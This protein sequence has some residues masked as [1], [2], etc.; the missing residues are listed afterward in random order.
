MALTR[1]GGVV[2]RKYTKLLG[3]MICALRDTVSKR[4]GELGAPY[5]LYGYFGCLNAPLYFL[6]WRYVNPEI[7]ENGDLRVLCVLL[8]IPLILHRR[9]PETWRKWLPLY[10]YATL[11]ITLPAFFTCLLVMNQGS[12]MWMANHIV[13]VFFV[14]LLVDSISALWLLSLGTVLGIAFAG[15]LSPH[16]MIALQTHLYPGFPITYAISVV[17]GLLFCRNREQLEKITCKNLQLAAECAEKELFIANLSHDLRTPLTGLVG[18]ADYALQA[19]TP[20]HPHYDTLHIMHQSA[21]QL[22]HFCEN[23]LDSAKLIQADP[24]PPPAERFTMQ[25]LAKRIAHLL[26]PALTRKKLTLNIQASDTDQTRPLIGH[27][28]W[29]TLILIHLINNAI[30][31]TET[32]TITLGWEIQGKHKQ[33]KLILTVCD[34]G[35]GMTEATQSQIFKAFKQAKPAYKQPTYTGAGLGLYQVKTRVQRLGG[36]VF[37]KSEGLGCGSMFTCLLPVRVAT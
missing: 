30:Q 35:Q 1:T 14:L 20:Q 2:V 25:P 6:I 9:W 11:L 26:Q 32:G 15:V 13:M 29:I 31:F 18:M 34:T 28:N 22:H 17:I 19:I 33:D 36:N 27:P 10:W 4:V 16:H 21:E 24:T 8:C 12:P 5:A 3:G 7:Y 37:V 23:L